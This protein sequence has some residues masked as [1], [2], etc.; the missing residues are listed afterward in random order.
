MRSVLPTQFRGL[1]APKKTGGEERGTKR[2]RERRSGLYIANIGPSGFQTG[3][4]NTFHRDIKIFG[5]R[6]GCVAGVL[7]GEKGPAD[8]LLLSH[9]PLTGY[10]LA[11]AAAMWDEGRPWYGRH[12]E[13][14]PYY[15]PW[16]F[17]NAHQGQRQT[18]LCASG[19]AILEAP[20]RGMA[21]AVFVTRRWFWLSGEAGC[22]GLTFRRGG[23][24]FLMT[25]TNTTAKTTAN[26]RRSPAACK[27]CSIEAG[28][29]RLWHSRSSRDSSIAKLSLPPG[30]REWRALAAPLD[31]R[32]I[33]VNWIDLI[34]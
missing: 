2:D 31:T 6:M 11:I 10:S 30:I 19:L 16:S 15:P 23:S 13:F 5:R 24:R 27:L 4:A 8:F 34:L 26:P 21:S 17:A 28:I 33:S 29:A 9:S 25:A 32:I 20:G 12:V 3:S 1:K 7:G 14:P 18:R 22:Y